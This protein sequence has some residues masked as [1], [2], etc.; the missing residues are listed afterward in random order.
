MYQSLKAEEKA[1][2]AREKEKLTKFRDF[3]SSDSSMKLSKP[4]VSR[5]KISPHISTIVEGEIQPNSDSNSAKSEHPVSPR[6]RMNEARAVSEGKS[7]KF[8]QNQARNNQLEEDKDTEAERK[9]QRLNTDVP[10]SESSDSDDHNSES[11]ET[12][13]FWDNDAHLTARCLLSKGRQIYKNRK[14]KQK[15]LTKVDRRSTLVSSDN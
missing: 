2:V 15:I 14:K 11:S 8:D 6:S 1:A 3:D 12:N 7:D 10:K 4:L 9:R 5:S 13:E